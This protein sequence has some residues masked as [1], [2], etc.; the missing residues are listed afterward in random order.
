VGETGKSAAGPRAG[1][2]TAL[3]L[4]FAAVWPSALAWL[5]A[6]ALAGEDGGPVRQALY[7]AGKAVQLLFPIA[8]VLFVERRRPRPRPPKAKDWLLGLGPGLAVAAGMLALY[9][10]WLR[11]A[12]PLADT[13]QAIRGKLAEFG[14]D[15]PWK[16]LALAVSLSAVNSLQEEYYFRWFLFGRLRAFLPL[17]PALI[18]AALAFAAHHVIL[19]GLYLPGRFWT[20]AVPLALCVG[21]GGGLWAWLYARTGAL[22]APW[23]CHVLTDAAVFAVGWDLLRKAGL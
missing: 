15:S 21:A 7:V 14:V 20:A 1:A 2:A 17:W 3:A 10:A 19:L 8:F 22:Y 23:L 5:Y 4:L 16:Y 9:F 11:G 13:P 12:P 6:V 18:L